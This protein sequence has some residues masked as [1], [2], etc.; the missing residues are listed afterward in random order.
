MSFDTSTTLSASLGGNRATC[1]ERRQSESR[2]NYR[3]VVVSPVPSP[4]L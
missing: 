2:F 4:L 3:A 1:T